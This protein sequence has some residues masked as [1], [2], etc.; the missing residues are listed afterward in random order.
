M[1]EISPFIIG[2]TIGITMGIIGMNLW[3]NNEG[4]SLKGEE[5]FYKN[6]CDNGVK[7]IANMQ[8]EYTHRK[9]KATNIV[10]YKY[11]YFVNGIK[12]TEEIITNKLPKTQAFE[13]TYLPSN[14]SLSSISNVCA[15]YER[16][17][18]DTS[19]S[20]LMYIG[21]VMFFIGLL[22][23]WTSFKKL[24]KGKAYNL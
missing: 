17:K 15:T 21:I 12:Y 5:D 14:P 22:T 4:S 2:I 6:L 3:T 23:A 24:I 18:N 9:G 10:S 16:I 7:T 19:S 13:I 1:K 20:S 11:D 8:D